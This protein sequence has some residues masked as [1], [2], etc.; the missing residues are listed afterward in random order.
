[1]KN[2][3]VW[4]IMIWRHFHYYF[5]FSI[6]NSF[7]ITHLHIGQNH[8][9]THPNSQQLMP[10]EGTCNPTDNTACYD[11]L[12]NSFASNCRDSNHHLHSAYNQMNHHGTHYTQSSR[13]ANVA[14]HMQTFCLIVPPLQTEYI[15]NSTHQ[16]NAPMTNVNHHLDHQTNNMNSQMQW[17]ENPSVHNPPNHSTA[18]AI[19]FL[20]WYSN[21]QS[22]SCYS[23]TRK[24]FNC[25]AHSS[26]FQNRCTTT[27]SNKNV[28]LQLND[29]E[30]SQVSHLRILFKYHWHI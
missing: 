18:T 12:S 2:G 7:W 10:H 6:Q 28:L 22:T 21:G 30:Q 19:M 25:L 8:A 15:Q 20:S 4:V 13:G 23:K 9:S 16:A 27:E 11:E 5:I 3:M 26:I 1:M 29:N 14:Q 24:K 17:S